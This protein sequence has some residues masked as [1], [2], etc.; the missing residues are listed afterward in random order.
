LGEELRPYPLTT[1][2]ALIALQDRSSRSENQASLAYLKNAVST[3]NSALGLC[4]AALCLDLY[5][6]D[7][8]DVWQRL[9]RCYQDT[10]FL[11]D[12][13]TAALVLIVL[14]ARKTKNIFDLKFEE[15]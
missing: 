7:C 11:R 1:A 13:K 2:L 9:S 14:Q 12:I 3:E 4:F 6:Q 8:E 15:S 10:L 5:A